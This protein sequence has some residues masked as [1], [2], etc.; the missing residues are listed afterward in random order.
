MGIFPMS[1]ANN[2]CDMPLPKYLDSKT[3][4]IYRPHPVQYKLHIV[5]WSS[6][7]LNKI[8]LCRITIVGL[9]LVSD[10]CLFDGELIMW[11]RRG[12]SDIPL[13]L[14]NKDKLTAWCSRMSCNLHILHIHTVM[15]LPGFLHHYWRWWGCETDSQTDRQTFFPAHYYLPLMFLVM[16]WLYF[17][18]EHVIMYS[19]F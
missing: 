12:R 8:T 18:T 16:K 11:S 7:A 4:L 17:Y 2:F 14:Q 19:C 1:V 15:L 5:T 6:S 10:T 13:I 9:I 3:V